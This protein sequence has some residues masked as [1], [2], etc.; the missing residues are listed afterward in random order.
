MNILIIE[1]DKFLAEKL[2]QVFENKVI[3]NR[4]KIINSYLDFI[5]E[6][7]ILS[8]Y[9]IVLT[10]IKL[11]K[12]L[13]K[14]WI[15]IVEIIREKK[16]PIPIIVMSCFSDTDWIER[17][18]NKW[19]ND[20]II[21]PFRLK[22]L[23]LRVQNWFKSYYISSKNNILTQVEY[24][25]LSYDLEINEFSYKKIC[26][27]LTKK[28]KYILS[29]FFAKPDTLISE[30]T[31]V[32]KIWGDAFLIKDRNLRVCILRL[33]RALEPYGIDHWITN[34]RGEWYILQNR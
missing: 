8:S 20:Y 23:E 11:W 6:I 15:N 4:I 25:D 5:E 9:D 7:N 24:W 1:D 19:A 31:L 17:A 22:E 3:S 18:F 28:S 13:E 12:E 10:D 16:I 32:D 33:K 29:I 34:R 27:P 2:K 14:N 21:K 26:L 30:E